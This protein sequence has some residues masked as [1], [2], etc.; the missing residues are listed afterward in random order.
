MQH[1]FSSG[2]Y[3]NW[4]LAKSVELT[5]AAS[6]SCT[7]HSED[8]FEGCVHSELG[9]VRLSASSEEAERTWNVL[10]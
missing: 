5:L 9:N 8:E 4:R 3:L 2:H 7:S 1:L 6:T 10:A